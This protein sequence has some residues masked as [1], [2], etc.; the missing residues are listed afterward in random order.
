MGTKTQKS[1]ERGKKERGRSKQEGTSSPAW[2][3]KGSTKITNRLTEETGT[4]II[5][6]LWICIYRILGMS[7]QDLWWSLGYR[8]LSCPYFAFEPSL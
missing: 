8:F 3:G 7:K 2:A 1:T 6:D 4:E 5:K